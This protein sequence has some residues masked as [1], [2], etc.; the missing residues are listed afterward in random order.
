VINGHVA[1]AIFIPRG[2]S[3]EIIV[4]SLVDI[5]KASEKCK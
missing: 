4:D 3:R 1:L 5:G 2:D